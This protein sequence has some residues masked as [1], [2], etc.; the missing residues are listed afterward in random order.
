M[1]SLHTPGPWLRIG[2]NIGTPD[3]G[4]IASMSIMS[5]VSMEKG[6]RDANARLIAAAPELL[7]TL[8]GLVEMC[9]MHG[10]FSNGVTDPTG[11]TIDEGVIRAGE[12]IRAASAA[13]AKATGGAE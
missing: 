4:I 12:V 5:I 2:T 13:I 3:G 11:G 6:E 9:V 8:I 10:D 1:K 7:D